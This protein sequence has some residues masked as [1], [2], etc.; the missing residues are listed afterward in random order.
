MDRWDAFKQVRHVYIHYVYTFTC[1]RLRGRLRIPRRTRRLAEPVAVELGR[2]LRDSPQDPI[3]P[4]AQL[5]I[6]AREVDNIAAKPEGKSKD[7]R[8]GGEGQ[9]RLVEEESAG[10]EAQ[11]VYPQVQMP[12]PF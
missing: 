7:L 1:I 9:G 2:P 12:E 8:R 4:V 3:D 5:G 6:A 11:T 10:E